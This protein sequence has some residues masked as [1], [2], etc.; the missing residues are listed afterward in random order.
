MRP[1]IALLLIA[2]TCPAADVF[3]MWWNDPATPAP[4]LAFDDGAGKPKPIR[5]LRLCPLETT[6]GRAGEVWTLLQKVPATEPGLPPTWKPY[7]QTKLA[8]NAERVALLLVP[9][10]PPQ[11]M[12]VEISE[13]SH[14]WGS[15]RF[16]NLTG[17]P[18]QGWIGKST[19]NLVAG[20]QVA[21]PV[22]SERRT[23]EV[24]MMAPVPGAQP[25]VL[26]SSRVILDPTRRSV[27]FVA[28]LAN[29]TVETRAI[30]ESRD[31]EADASNNP[32][33][34]GAR[35]PAGAGR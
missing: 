33:P 24:V 10:S 32:A 17:G 34:G 25:R 9:S 16:V 2:A 20:G 35:K 23:E 29:G 28:K 4:E 11:A 18:I 22:V 21:S 6:K 12:A 1:F 26:M 15:V 27:I 14:P 30:E 5:I 7:V 3:P 13:R 19:F 31:L 8:E